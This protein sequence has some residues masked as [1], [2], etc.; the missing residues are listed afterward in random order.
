MRY[1]NSHPIADG[2]ANESIKFYP[3]RRSSATEQYVCWIDVMG[4]RGAMLYS[5]DIA[6][7]F[8]MKLHIAALRIS[9]IFNVELYPAIDGVYACSPSQPSILCFL[10]Q[11]Y[12][13]LATTFVR[14]SV[15]LFK[16]KVRSGLAYGQVV[17]GKQI[18]NCTDD[19]VL[20]K[21]SRH[22]RSILLGSPLAHAYEAEMKAPPFGI[23]LDESAKI[24][25]LELCE[26]YLKWWELYPRQDDPDLACELYFSLK[27]HY[28][29]CD[30]NSIKIRYPQAD[31]K[32]HS[33]LVDEYFAEFRL[34]RAIFR[35]TY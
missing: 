1:Q 31:I 8:L 3:R 19:D 17:M 23:L 18:L 21:Y 24:G 34:N 15:E 12:S 30:K 32:K 28:E 29:W 11:V 27:N 9:K 6:S 26:K 33:A 10:N 4:S 20:K 5:I 25:Q 7:N 35:R 16:F 22:T 2:R 13:M 14:E